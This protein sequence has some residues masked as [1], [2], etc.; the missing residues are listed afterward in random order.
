MKGFVQVVTQHPTWISF[1]VLCCKMRAQENHHLAAGF[2]A[3]K[4][5]DFLYKL[6]KV[7]YL[8]LRKVCV[9]CRALRSVL[10]CAPRKSS[11]V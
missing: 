11:A 2:R 4:S 5:N 9:C 7:D 6:P 3:L 10:F 1:I 8:R